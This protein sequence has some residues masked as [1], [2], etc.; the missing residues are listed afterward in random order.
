MEKSKPNWRG[1]ITD[2]ENA[3]MCLFN[4]TSKGEMKKLGPARCLSVWV[5]N[6][7][8]LG[9]WNLYHQKITQ[10]ILIHECFKCWCWT[11]KKDADKRDGVRNFLNSLPKMESHYCRAKTS[12][13]Y[14]EPNWE[15]KSQLY[16]EYSCLCSDR[17][18]EPFFHKICITMNLGFFNH[19][20]V[21]CETCIKH[22]LGNISQDLFQKYQNRKGVR[23]EK[24]SDKNISD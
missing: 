11:I 4:T 3:R 12:K 16:R 6:Q 9:Y 22:K 10:T 7:S 19:K 21:Q 1:T 14:L 5:N 13:E 8:N 2:I 24:G 15:T 20:K 18:T 17:N 23:K